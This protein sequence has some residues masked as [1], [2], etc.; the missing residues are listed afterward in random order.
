MSRRLRQ[1]NDCV[2]FPSCRRPAPRQ[3][4]KP[5]KEPR[6]ISGLSITHTP[7]S[8]RI[9]HNAYAYITLAAR[10]VFIRLSLIARPRLYKIARSQQIDVFVSSHC[11]QQIRPQRSNPAGIDER[12][13]EPIRRLHSPSCACAESDS[14]KTRNI[15]EAVPAGRRATPQKVPDGGSRP[16]IDVHILGHISA[17]SP[18]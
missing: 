1:S 9:H 15:E 5:R 6:K 3:R 4:C 14:A 12:I 7:T 2:A 10:L 13:N 8:P 17:R 18:Q 11:G 16:L